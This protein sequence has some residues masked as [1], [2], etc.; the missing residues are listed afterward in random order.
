[1]LP[2]RMT[3]KESK[4]IV[5]D[6]LKTVGKK[7][8]LWNELKSYIGL[9]YELIPEIVFYGEKIGWTLR[10]RRSGKTLCSFFPEKNAFTVLVVLGKKEVEKT[11]LLIDKLNKSVKKVFEETKQLHDGRWLWINVK[12]ATDVESIKVLLGVKRRPKKLY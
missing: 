11:K 8:L 10:Y 1:M 5:K 6:M 9:Y 7:S 12:T 3:D 2:Q 4:P